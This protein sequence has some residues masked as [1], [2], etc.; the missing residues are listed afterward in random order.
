[1]ENY[2]CVGSKAR[3][4]KLAKKSTN[5]DVNINKWKG[6]G[7]NTLMR[8]YNYLSSDEYNNN[9]LS[10]NVFVSRIPTE[11]DELLENSGSMTGFTYE[12]IQ[13]A[14]Y[15][16]K[17]VIPN[18]A[19]LDFLLD[20]QGFFDI[21]DCFLIKLDHGDG[22]TKGALFMGNTSGFTATICL[23][24]EGIAGIAV[25]NT[26]N[27]KSVVNKGDYIICRSSRGVHFFPQICGTSVFL[28]VNMV[29]SYRLIESGFIIQSHSNNS[30]VQKTVA[31]ICDSRLRVLELV[32]KILDVREKIEK[33]YIDS[34]MLMFMSNTYNKL[35]SKKIQSA[36][37]RELKGATTHLNSLVN[38][39]N[40]NMERTHRNEREVA[41]GTRRNRAL[42]VSSHRKRAIVTFHLQQLQEL[43]EPYNDD[44]RNNNDNSS[45]NRGP[46]KGS[47]EYLVQR[48]VRH[49]YNEIVKLWQE[50]EE[51]AENVDDLL[52]GESYVV[53]SY[54]A[55]MIAE[56]ESARIREELVNKLRA[57]SKVGFRR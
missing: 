53:N 52:N 6:S 11:A 21:S 27:F 4:V 54:V 49:I 23:K 31:R 9:I 55:A 32:S 29:P 3:K 26:S 10:D 25:P 20:K 16:W 2:L 33:N 38:I 47:L 24:N 22:F 7:L 43:F 18:E 34:C 8:R 39:I 12:Q 15:S 36:I 41:I 35:Y 37:D 42:S 45:R 51:L 19:L 5:N 56:G 28:I 57:L 14:S 1:M 30:E 50:M 48:D 13:D 17:K 46:L 40:N 44:C